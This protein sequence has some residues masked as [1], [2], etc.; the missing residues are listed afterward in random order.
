MKNDYPWSLFGMAHISAPSELPTLPG[1]VGG[2]R[3]PLFSGSPTPIERSGGRQSLKCLSKSIVRLTAFP[4]V[5]TTVG[6]PVY[7]TPG[8]IIQ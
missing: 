6:G 4:G 8:R 7:L 1:W 5:Y 3:V 2:I